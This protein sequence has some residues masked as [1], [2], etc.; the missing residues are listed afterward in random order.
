MGALTTLRAAT[1]PPA[2]G[3]EYYTPDR[4]AGWRGYPVRSQSSERSHDTQTH[5][6]LW[7]ESERLTGVQC[8]SP[9]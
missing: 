1:N 8:M 7:A 5:R 4:L 9:A 2:R 3:G 6:L